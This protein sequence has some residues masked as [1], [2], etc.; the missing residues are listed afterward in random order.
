MLIEKTLL[1]ISFA[2]F[3]V[4]HVSGRRYW[5]KIP[6]VGIL[7]STVLYLTAVLLILIDKS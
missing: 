4:R 2:I 6:L 3:D 1:S 7:I 5:F